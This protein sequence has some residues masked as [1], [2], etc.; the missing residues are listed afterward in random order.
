MAPH[1]S[2]TLLKGIDIEIKELLLQYIKIK[3][4]TGTINEHYAVDFLIGHLSQWTYFKENPEYYGKYPI[5]DDLHQRDVCYAMVKGQGKDTIVFLHHYDIVDIEDFRALKDCAFSP[6]ELE[7]ELNKIKASLH[8]EAKEDLDSKEYLFGRGTADMKSGGA[9]QLCL[10]KRYSEMKDFP[11]NI[12]LIAVPDEENLSAGMRG[13]V[14][15][16]AS[17]QEKYQLRYKLMINSEPH[18][19]VQKNTGILSEGTIGKMMPFVYVRGFLSHIG[20]I[21][22]GLNPLNILSEIVRRTELNADLSDCYNNEMAPPPTWLYLKDSKKH[23]DV[24]IPLSASGCFSILTLR[25]TPQEVMDKMRNI[26][27]DS[28]IEV[29][30]KANVGYEKFA[31]IKGLAKKSLPW[32]PKVLTFGEL[33]EE[34]ERS[35]GEKFVKFYDKNFE[36]IKEKVNNGKIS[37]I[38]SNFAL[39]ETIY[40]FIDDLSPKVIIGLS[41]PYYPSVCN[42]MIENKDSKIKDLSQFLCHS[43]ESLTGMPYATEYF[44]TGI[45]DLSYSS[46]S[47]TKK[48]EDTLSKTMPLF[49]KLYELPLKEL[50][51]ISMPGINIGPWGKDFHKLTERVLKKDLLES[52]PQI[53]H[54][55]VMHVLESN[56]ND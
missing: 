38:E 17:L 4:Y 14:K 8:Q 27:E 49:G 51:Q 54:A 48:V 22:E 6:D 35:Y 18:Q 32:T 12:V 1:A 47:D 15:L 25:Q 36:Q 53:L 52:T 56:H 50:E 42:F 10:L 39:I 11:G 16:L 19:R 37:M 45:S 29:I 44:F 31:K 2:H 41:P 40:Q 55:A 28:F 34:A 23:Y 7:R 3:S 5:K 20:K 43:A 30:Q 21:Y 9:I 26:C 13:A 33:Y 24:S 46:M